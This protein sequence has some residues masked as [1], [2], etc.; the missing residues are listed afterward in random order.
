MTDGYSK[1]KYHRRRVGKKGG[2]HNVT[3]TLYLSMYISLHIYIYIFVYMYMI[4]MYMIHMYSIYIYIYIYIYIHK[5]SKTPLF[6]SLLNQIPVLFEFIV[7]FLM[8]K[9]S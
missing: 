3:L 6:R 9:N 1:M 8:V 2:S 4:Y 7:H 5:Y